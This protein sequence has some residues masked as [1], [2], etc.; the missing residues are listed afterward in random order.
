[1]VGKQTSINDALLHREGTG[2]IRRGSALYKL[3]HMQLIDH[4]PEERD[5]EWWARCRLEHICVTPYVAYD[6][7][8]TLIAGVVFSTFMSATFVALFALTGC[9]IGLCQRTLNRRSEMPGP[10]HPYSQTFELMKRLMVLRTVMWSIFAGTALYNAPSELLVALLP[11][12]VMVMWIESIALVAVPR[13]AVLNAAINGMAIALPLAFVGGLAAI[14]GSAVALASLLALHWLVFHLNYMFAT[15]RLRTRKL[16]E[17]NDTIQLL[18]NQ[19]DQD[20]SDW[21]FECTEAGQILRPSRRFCEA[22]GRSAEQLEGMQL[23]DLFY[24]SPER[25]DLREMGGQDESFQ[26][27]VVPLRIRGEHRWWSISARKVTSNDDENRRYWRGFVAD[28]TCAREAEARIKYM[29]HYDV[30]TDLPNRA[31]FNTTIKRAFDRMGA[32]GKVAILAI[33]LDHFKTIN[34]TFGHTGGDAALEEAARRI[35]QCVPPGAM[36]ARFGGDE[37]AV[38]IEHP[39]TRERAI[40]VAHKIV[41]AMN[42]PVDVEGQK[43]PVGASVGIAFAPDDGTTCEEVIYAADLA[44]YDAKSR[45]RKAASVFEPRMHD[46]VQERHQLELELRDALTNGELEVHYQPLV[47][48]QSVQ[49][50]GYEAL[51]RWNHPKRGPVSPEVFIPIAEDN[52]QIVQIGEWVLREALAEAAR[53]PEHLTISVNLS[54]VQTMDAEL[55]GIIVHALASSS[56]P[57]HRLELEI[58]ESV[59]MRECDETI[60]LLHKIRALGVRIALDDFGTGYS[61]LNYLRA[62]P[63][64]KIKIDRCFV[65]DIAEREHSDAIVQA[66]IALATRLNMRTTAEGIENTEQMERLRA[67]ECSEMQGYLFSRALPASQLPHRIAC[68]TDDTAVVTRLPSESSTQEVDAERRVEATPA[69]SRQTG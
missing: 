22:S 68:E 21:L 35:E 67:T 9:V 50:V 13:V 46:E 56:V 5:I 19:Y 34:D 48:T 26:R 47:D 62:F 54:P 53:W 30:L 2:L 32:D 42:Q 31:L 43:A 27:L 60:A 18:L 69:R 63:F 25:A 6:I 57:A 12:A 52:G 40:E 29:A 66:V 51:L 45:G 24:D 37:F 4:Q 17:A 39:L 7:L 28:V 38:L 33:D 49:T 64:D 16:T 65:G 61:S 20:G 23:L 3:F 8:R 41:R 55:Y 44:L 10:G 11:T 59:L 14:G 15:R 58:T 1:M 36:V